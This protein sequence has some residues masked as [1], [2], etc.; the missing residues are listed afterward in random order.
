[1]Y[2][3]CSAHMDLLLGELVEPTSELGRQLRQR[4]VCGGWI[5]GRSNGGRSDDAAT[6]RTTPMQYPGS[7]LQ[8]PPPPVPSKFPTVPISTLSALRMGLAWNVPRALLQRLVER[9][10]IV[11]PARQLTRRCNSDNAP[12][13]RQSSSCATHQ[14]T[15][16]H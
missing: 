16:R 2:G 7:T 13:M 10:K 11:E 5:G 1:M 14:E 12:T 6:T 4:Q 3:A 9:F 8:Y 15:N